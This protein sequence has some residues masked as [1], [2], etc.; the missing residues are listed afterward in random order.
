MSDQPPNDQTLGALR[1]DPGPLPGEVRAQ[2]RVSEEISRKIRNICFILSVTV[3]FNHAI[4]YTHTWDWQGYREEPLEPGYFASVPIEVAVQHFISGALGR[5]TNPVFFMVSGFL[6]FYAWKPDRP[7]WQRKLRRR[8]FTLLIPYFVWGII[9]KFLNGLNLYAG[10]VSFLLNQASDYSWVDVLITFWN[11]HPPTQL[12]FLRDLMLMMVIGV[13][14]ILLLVRLP[15]IIFSLII[16]VA[17]ALPWFAVVDKNSLCF[18]TAGAYLGFRQ[19]NPQFTSNRTRFWCIAVSFT[20]GIAYTI[21]AIATDWNLR[22]LFKAMIISGITGIWALYD[23]FPAAAYRFLDRFSP[24][25]FFVYMGFDPL[26]PIL[27]IP[28]LGALPVTQASR[29]AVFFIL[30]LV[31]AAMCVVVAMALHRVAPKAYYVITG[32]RLPGGKPNPAD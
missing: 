12:W 1:D 22:L 16:L 24:Y 14:L 15:P 9:G 25:R 30:P 20:F 8:A 7:S 21:L 10:K 31:V 4:T 3:I 11:M 17:Y 6:F 18:F 32:G 29:L 2:K 26:L 28:I 5:I 19:F 13:P 23:F 27:Q